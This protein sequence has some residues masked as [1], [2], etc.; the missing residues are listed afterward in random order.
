MTSK[1]RFWFLLPGGT[2]ALVAALASTSAPIRAQAPHAHAHAP[3]QAKQLVSPVPPTDAAVDAGRQIYVEQCASCHG[4]DGRAKT[5]RAATMKVKPADLTSEEMRALTEGE[6]FWTIG[7]GIKASGMPAF[8]R[9]LS[10]TE[11]WQTVAYLR[12]LRPAAPATRTVAV[13][14]RA[15]VGDRPLSCT[16]TFEGIGTTVSR[17]NVTDFRFFIHDVRLMTAAGGEEPVVL[18]QDGRWQ[19]DN[20]ALLDFEDGSGTCAN[21]SADLH[22]RVTG[23]ARAGAYAGVRFTVGVPFE[24]NHRDPVLAPPPLNLSRL[25]WVWNAGYKFA[26]FDFRTTGQPQGWVLHLGST[27]CSP[28]ETM[29]TVP[30]SCEHPNRVDVRLNAF[31]LD[32]DAV[33]VDVRA[34]LDGSNVDENTPDTAAGC[35]SGQNDPECGPIFERLGLPFG[36]RPSGPQRVFARGSAASTATSAFAWNLPRGFPRPRVPAD[37]PMTADKV[38]LGRHLF[39]DTRLSSTG[40]FSCATCHEQARAF[41]DGKARGVGVTGQVH[42]R[43]PMSLANVAYSPVLT[44]ANPLVRD[45]ERQALVPMLGETPVELGLAGQED[46]L[47]ARLRAVDRYRE[48][49][50]RAFPADRSPFSLSN[51]TKA[52]ASFERTLISGRSP[53]DRYRFG[54]D[55]SAISAAAKRGEALFFDERTECFH[56]HGGFNFTETVDYDTKDGPEIE[57]HNTGLYNVGG[58]GAYPADNTGVHGVTGQAQD[59]GRFKAPTLRNIAMTAPYMHDGSIATLDEVL[60]HYAAGGRTISSGPFAGV[61]RDNVHKSSF[62]KGF[63]LSPDERRDLLE[64]LGSLTDEAFLRDPRLADPWPA[65]DATAAAAR[66]VV[67]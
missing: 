12:R 15:T 47:F 51:V 2:I 54:G 4:A 32:R 16:D 44:W 40:T 52:I 9:D 61:G 64:F 10:E 30:T 34:L 58:S 56:C 6:L 60:D 67:R 28:R 59:M 45:L 39:Y 11:R 19:V 33:V 53:Y 65:H 21:G 57:F 17:L 41:T 66:G 55:A 42:P 35:M 20:V 46:A 26:R 31:D 29:L 7:N 38:E 50:A 24:K 8:A 48:L 5:R 22:T 25:F 43:G 36:D 23:T 3:G 13:N 27:D 63:R 62:V 37:N 14:F 49:F 1:R 18:D